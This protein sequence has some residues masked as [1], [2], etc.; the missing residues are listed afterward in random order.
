MKKLNILLFQALLTACL[1][2]AFTMVQ[3]QDEETDNV[4]VVWYITAED[5]KDSEFE[6]AVKGFHEFMADKEGHWEWQWYS[7]LTGPDTGNYL[8]RSGN[9]NWA[10]MDVD[11]DWDDEVN[12]YFNENV[13]RS[14]AVSEDETY[15][16]P[17]S[18][19]EYNY[20]RVTDWHIKQGQGS[21]FNSNLKKIHEALQEGGWG[22]YYTFSY[23]SSGGRAGDAVLVTPH[24]NWADMAAKEP[25]FFSV[26]SETLGEEEAQALLDT[27]GATYKAGEV[28]TL[29]WRKDMNP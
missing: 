10:D 9:H 22:G 1:I 13:T 8:A 12:A 7:I 21:E 14:I 17:E 27:F 3:A 19:D 28:R 26:L 20:F 24:K 15:H 6:A 29:R 2:S 16:W 23:N 5:G 18:M 11:N 4:A 25:S